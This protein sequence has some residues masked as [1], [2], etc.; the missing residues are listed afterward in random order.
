MGISSC[1]QKGGVTKMLLFV[2]YYFLRYRVLFVG[3]F[4]QDLLENEQRT[5][6]I[7][8]TS[9]LQAACYLKWQ[10]SCLEKRQ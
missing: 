1:P 7:K 3:N 8:I 5:T 10:K 9:K 6:S 2:Y 4:A